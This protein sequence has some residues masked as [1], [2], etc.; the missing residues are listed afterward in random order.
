MTD[1]QSTEMDATVPSTD[2][3]EPSLTPPFVTPMTFMDDVEPTYP[4][5]NEAVH[6]YPTSKTA[7]QGSKSD[8]VQEKRDNIAL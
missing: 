7:D 8:V 6:H 1:I 4:E 5:M 3:E 2:S